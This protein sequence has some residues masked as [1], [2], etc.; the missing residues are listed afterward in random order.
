MKKENIRE[1]IS[2]VLTIIMRP[3]IDLETVEQMNEIL[4]YGVLKIIC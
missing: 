3:E 2:V 4:C 1:A